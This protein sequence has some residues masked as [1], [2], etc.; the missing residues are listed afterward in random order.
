MS[1]YLGAVVVPH[2]PIIV[3][4][5]GKGKEKEAQITVDGLVGIA[6]HIS[7]LKPQVIICIT[8]HGNVF[9][10]GICVLDKA[11]LSGS[12]ANF[13]NPDLKLT[14]AVNQP[15]LATI[16]S[17]FQAEQI[18]SVFMDEKNAQ[19]YQVS[20]ELDHGCLVPL[21]YIDREYT[22]YE[23]VHITVG[24]MST[25]EL[26]E[27]GMA[28]R[29]AI[30]N[31]GIPTVVMASGDLS[32]TLKEDGPYGYEPAGPEFDNKIVE[33]FRSNELQKIF[34]ISEDVIEPAATCA[35]ESIVIT[36]GLFEGKKVDAHV[37]S[38]EGPFGV[39]YMNAIL[40]GADI[41]SDSILQVIEQ[42]IEERYNARKKSED[43]Y[44][45]FAR[46]VITEWVHNKQELDWSIYKE[47]IKDEKIV[48]RL[49]QEQAGVFVSIHKQGQLRGCIG[50]IEPT[51]VKLAD[52]MIRNAIAAASEDP[53]FAPV[54]PQE[55][56]L[57]DIKVDI[58]HPPEAI[59]RKSQL[60]IERYGVIVESGD[61]R[62]LLL[63]N[64][65]GINS[66]EEQVAIARQKAG[67]AAD[68]RVK[69]YRF[70]VERHEAK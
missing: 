22:N 18:P 23:I 35:M 20:T 37:L 41:Q 32:H 55:L 50:T 25:K 28:L 31:A 47:L 70:E 63:P 4:E 52:E 67:I 2:P 38:Y 27:V 5:I 56:Q 53:R 30:D 39:G 66:I 65:D 45:Q 64:I 40:S 21:Y 48:K 57:L 6:K 1:K 69:M 34:S 43:D 24:K 19:Q 58:L 33:A 16:K 61:K 8:P 26:Y 14:K 46:A 15:F 12:F 62:G 17:T 29:T 7:V 9:S 59:D 54:K 42:G 36:L 11:E 13:G 49:E 44:V 10:D 60:D 51:S 68:E 3:P